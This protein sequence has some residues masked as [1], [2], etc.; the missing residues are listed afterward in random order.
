MG[1]EI[2]AIIIRKAQSGMSVTDRWYLAAELNNFR[3]AF[4]RKTAIFIHLNDLSTQSSSH[5]TPQ[6]DLQVRAF[7]SLEDAIEWVIVNGT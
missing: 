5:S 7:T 1:R 6:T 3:K 4:S 2:F